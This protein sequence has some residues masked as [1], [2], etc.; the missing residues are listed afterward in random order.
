[1][2]NLVYGYFVSEL[3]ILYFLCKK[4]N[5]NKY[6]EIFQENER[7]IWM[8]CWIVEVIETSR[9]AFIM[10]IPMPMNGL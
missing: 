4:H 8:E 1:M 2:P 6:N 10:Y 5:G 3:T 7:E 9:E